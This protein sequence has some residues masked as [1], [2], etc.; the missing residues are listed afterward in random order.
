[1]VKQELGNDKRQHKR[2]NITNGAFALL[3]WNG[4]EVLGAIKDI[5]S[6]GLCLSHI[7]ENE[8][9]Q[10]LTS[11]TVNLISENTCHENFLGRCIW[12]QKEEDRFA[13]SRVKMKRCGIAF[14]QLDDIQQQQ[15]REF[16]SCIE[17]K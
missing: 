6:G 8:N 3:K 12:N 4:A 10:N 13:T 16:I 1:M 14:R 7:D 5:S 9:L 17:E 11:L 2:Y 15:L